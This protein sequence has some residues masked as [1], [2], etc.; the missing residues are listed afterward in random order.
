MYSDV[1]GR[2]VYTAS[3]L[4]CW[5]VAAICCTIHPSRYILT[6]WEYFVLLCGEVNGERQLLFWFDIG[7]VILKPLMIKYVWLAENSS[8]FLVSNLLTLGN[9]KMH[10]NNLSIY[11]VL[12]FQWLSFLLGRDVGFRSLCR[13]CSTLYVNRSHY[14]LL[15]ACDPLGFQCR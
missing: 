7:G 3:S 8:F 6:Y 9:W 1:D 11:F 4:S 2:N 12:T 13:C 15:Q 14:R 10:L 5:L